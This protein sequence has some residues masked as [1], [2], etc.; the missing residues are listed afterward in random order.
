MCA[1]NSRVLISDTSS[2]HKYRPGVLQVIFK[3]QLSEPELNV[4]VFIRGSLLLLQGGGTRM[5]S[6]QRPSRM[7]G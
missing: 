5:R 6:A 2:V 3:R 4:W 1:V 7:Q